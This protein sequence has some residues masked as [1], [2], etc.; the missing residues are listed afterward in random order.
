MLKKSLIIIGLVLL[1]GTISASAANVEIGLGGQ[2]GNSNNF[3]LDNPNGWSLSVSKNLGPKGSIGFAYHHLDNNMRYHG[4]MIFG[5]PPPDYDRD[6]EFIQSDASSSI[7][8]LNLHFD[9]LPIDRFILGGTIGMSI[10]TF[11]L[12]LVGETSDISVSADKKSVGTMIGAD[13][14]M[15]KFVLPSLAMRLSVQYRNMSNGSAALDA[16]EPFLDINYTSVNLML[17]ARL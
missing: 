14:T 15:N 8:E 12:G 11:D 7:Y 4:L 17:L 6:P 10:A 3:Y 9:F 1:T 2:V 13:L 5:F 16:F